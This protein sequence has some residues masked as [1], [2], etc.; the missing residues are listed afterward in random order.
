VHIEFFGSTEA[1]AL[2]KAS[3]L[4]SLP[5]DGLS[6]LDADGVF[7]D[8][9]KSFS[10]SRVITVSFRGDADYTCMRDDLQK[11][12]V[13]IREKQTGETFV[14]HSILP[15]AHNVINAMFAIAVG[16]AHGIDWDRI[17]FALESYTPLPMRWEEKSVR[18]IKVI[19]DAYNANPLSMRVAIKTFSEESAE[20]GKWLVL[21]GMLELGAKEADEHVLLGEFVGGKNWAGLVVV[22]KLGGLIAKGAEDAGF[23]KDLVFRCKDNAAAAELLAVRVKAGDQVFFKASRGMHLEE[24]A[25]RF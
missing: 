4:K 24:V 15:G 2:E 22:G 7:F 3:L 12:E 9:L 11:K 5:G 18:G 21:A 10:P 6:V 17:R 14:F 16:R 13:L 25:G 19:N 23:G 20:G 8:L 1:I